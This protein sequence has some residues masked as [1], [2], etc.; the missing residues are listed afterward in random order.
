MITPRK[1]YLS[2]LGQIQQAISSE[3]FFPIP[4]VEQIYKIDLNTRRVEAPAFLSVTDDN[5]A[6]ILF[7]EVDRFF[8]KKDL[9][10]TTCVILYEN[11][12]RE[13]FMYPVPCMD[14]ETKKEENK[15]LLPWVINSDVTWEA[16]TV[17]F[18]F[19]FYEINPGTLK[20]EY[21]LNTAETVTRVLQG[22]RFYY[23]DATSRAAAD[24]QAGEWGKKYINY[25][26]KVANTI[27][28]S[29][30]YQHAA[31]T[32]NK[33]ETYYLR[34]EEFRISDGTKL[35]AIYASLDTLKK[36]ALKWMEI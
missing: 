23:V 34:E 1:E 15:I 20:F 19:Q 8:D 22:M 16:G 24:Y 10:Q 36:N 27:G 21:T 29:Y 33:E 25:F 18:A 13:H 32:Y 2:K 11:A 5:E 30:R 6:E 9:A 14:L 35:E 28:N 7:F 3:N 31:S 4:E 26:T 17:K 12:A